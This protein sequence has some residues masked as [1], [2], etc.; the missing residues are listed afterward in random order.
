[1]QSF[2][3]IAAR[4]ESKTGKKLTV[5]HTPRSVLEANISKDPND[6]LSLL[7]LVWDLGEGSVGEVNAADFYPG[8]NPKKIFDILGQ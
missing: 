2:N 7:P 4:Y 6:L 8:W 1:M 5:T 3:Q